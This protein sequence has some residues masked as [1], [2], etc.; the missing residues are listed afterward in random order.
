MNLDVSHHQ[1]KIDYY[2]YSLS[3]M[4]FTVATMN[5][6]GFP[7]G[8]VSKESTCNA[9]TQVQPLG[10][11]EDPLEKEMEPIP[12]FLPGKSHGQGEPGWL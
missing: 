4:N 12:A 2:I 8:W 7:G 1:L 9:K 6:I 10:Q 3:Y 11:E 5:F